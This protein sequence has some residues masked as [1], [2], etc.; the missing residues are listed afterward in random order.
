V[1]Y[2][3][4]AGKQ[5][6]D[7]QELEQKRAKMEEMSI[8]ISKVSSL[9]DKVATA[10]SKYETER[11]LLEIIYA[12]NDAMRGI[13]RVQETLVK[14][15]ITATQTFIPTIADTGK[16]STGMTDLGQL[17]KKSRPSPQL[18][19]ENLESGD[20]EEDKEMVSF[21]DAVRAAENSTLVFNLNMGRTPIM[22]METIS[23]KATIA[24]ATMAAGKEEGNNTSIPS[25]DTLAALDDALSVATRISFYG[26]KTKTYT[27][28]KD[29]L[30]G[31]FCT[32]PVKYEFKDKNSRIEAEKVFMDKCGAHCSVPYPPILRECIKQ[33]VAKV[34]KDYPNNQ[35]K[36]VVDTKTAS[37]RV[38]RRER[39]LD[40]PGKWSAFDVNVPLPREA[41]NVS[42]R[43]V[44]PDFKLDKLPPSPRKGKT[45]QTTESAEMDV[46]SNAPE[47]Y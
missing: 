37:L 25:E 3:H 17:A 23:N 36:V 6:I 40:N 34:K 32:I 35:V 7:Q 22:N 39:N 26:K 8:E 14:E 15:S 21:R 24:L 44:P 10:A 42:A 16:R 9:C 46:E 5:V 1:S 41:L 31:S 28:P 33:V 30:S 27:N 20:E 13:V 4:I 47:S 29:S 2:A 38:S 11:P 19:V 43:T 45:S 12:I 18:Q